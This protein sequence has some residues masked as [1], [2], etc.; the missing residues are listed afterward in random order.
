MPVFDYGPGPGPAIIGGHVYRGTNFPRMQGIYFFADFSLP[1]MW[2]LKFDGGAWQVARVLDENLSAPRIYWPSAFGED[3]AGELFVTSY[4]PYNIGSFSS[5]IM[6]VEDDGRCHPPRFEWTNTAYA[7]QV[8]VSSLTPRCRIH[9]TFEDREP[10][11]ND[12][13]IGSEEGLPVILGQTNRAR[14][15]RADLLPSQPAQARFSSLQVATPTLSASFEGTGVVVSASCITPGATLFYTTNGSGPTTNSSLYEG[16]FN[17]T[18]SSLVYVAGFRDGYSSSQYG[19]L[20]RAVARSM[21][22]TNGHLEI[23]AW[24]PKAAAYWLEASSDLR[25][26]RWQASTRIGPAL[27]VSFSYTGVASNY[28]GKQFFRIGGGDGLPPGLP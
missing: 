5:S 19:E 4:S 6:R 13:S 25:V 28:V 21:T 16:P 12:P 14:A 17:T 26:W 24:L 22:F 8:R 27:A 18:P 1:G 9:Y 23:V 20:T 2:G 11:E 15:F 10:T 7:P 3:E